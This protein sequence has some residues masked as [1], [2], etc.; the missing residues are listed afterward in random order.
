[1]TTTLPGHYAA[2]NVYQDI[3][4]RPEFFIGGATANDVR[5]GNDG[6]CWFMSALA[7]ISNKEEL[8]QRVCVARDEQVGVYG[9]VFHRG[10]HMVH[11]TYRA[12]T[13]RH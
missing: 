6:D 8:I 9:F 11:P 5:Q 13:N 10:M 4:D 7:T 2:T 3:F 12:S 1:M